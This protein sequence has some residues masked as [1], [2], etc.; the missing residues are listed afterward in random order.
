M[1]KNNH[2]K[3]LWKILL[4]LGILPFFLLIIYE[5][6]CLIYGFNFLFNTSYGLEA[7]RDSISIMA[8]LFWPIYILGIL[9][10]IISIIKLKKGER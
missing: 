9:L 3:L 8:Y 5:I 2:K 10:I 1:K 4:I 6:H 7:I